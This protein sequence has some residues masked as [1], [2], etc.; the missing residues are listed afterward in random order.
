[1]LQRKFVFS[2]LLQPAHR[3]E[4]QVAFGQV[5][6]SLA[7]MLVVLDLT[8]GLTGAFA[9]RGFR[10]SSDAC[11]HELSRLRSEACIPLYVMPR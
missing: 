11:K 6:L 2:P 8:Q 5:K 1:V 3:L 10:R 9:S 4:T 7:V